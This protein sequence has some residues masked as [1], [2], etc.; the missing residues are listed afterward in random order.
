M[1][2]ITLLAHYWSR[3]VSEYHRNIHYILMIMSI[4]T[5]IETNP[6]HVSH[7]II[8]LSEWCYIRKFSCRQICAGS[9]E[10]KKMECYFIQYDISP[11]KP[12]SSSIGFNEE[13]EDLNQL[14]QLLSIYYHQS[15]LSHPI[16]IMNSMRLLLGLD[17]CRVW[18]NRFV[19]ICIY[20]K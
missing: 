18:L 9:Y 4:Y 7:Y 12:S 5:L 6:S 10:V 16:L 2:L 13:Q 14:L 3:R 20:L 17:H 8:T 11:S 19:P 1:N 15:C